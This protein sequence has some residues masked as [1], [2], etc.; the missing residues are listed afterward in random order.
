ME[1][2]PKERLYWLID[3]LGEGRVLVPHPN[4]V[5]DGGWNLFLTNESKGDTYG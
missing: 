2:T 1:R 3:F 4:M 5:Y